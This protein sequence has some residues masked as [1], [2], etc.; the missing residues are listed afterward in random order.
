MTL[1]KMPKVLNN[2]VEII[3]DSM[4]LEAI[5]LRNVYR[6]MV[7]EKTQAANQVMSQI[8]TES[9]TETNLWVVVEV[10]VVAE[11]LGKN[12][13]KH[14][15]NNKIPWWKQ[16]IQTS[17][18]DLEKRSIMKRVEQRNSCLKRLREKVDKMKW[19]LMQK[20]KI[21]ERYSVPK[22][23]AYWKRTMDQWGQKNCKWETKAGG[24]HDWCG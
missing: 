22:C 21:L 14:K 5:N 11:L 8:H 2:I 1:M 12:R 19:N 17:I 16:Y 20:Y 10:D 18:V 15:N 23:R 4:N 7:Q 24:Y 3:K 6:K 13:S 9:I